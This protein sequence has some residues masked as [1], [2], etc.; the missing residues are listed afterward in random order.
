MYI[1]QIFYYKWWEL[2]K[3]G[4]LKVGRYDVMSKI[5]HFLDSVKCF[6]CATKTLCNVYSYS[7]IKARCRR[8]MADIGA[9]SRL[10]SIKVKEPFRCL[11]LGKNRVF[12]PSIK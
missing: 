9:V 7:T 6:I 2:G 12:L 1:H 5:C 4:L 10:V 11:P 8:N 3:V